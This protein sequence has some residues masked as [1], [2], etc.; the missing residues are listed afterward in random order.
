MENPLMSDGVLVRYLITLVDVMEREYSVAPAL[1]YSA[2]KLEPLPI[3]SAGDRVSVSYADKLWLAASQL[4][5]SELGLKLGAA[6]RYTSYASLGH[7]LMT[8]ETVGDAIRTAAENAHYVG[9]GHFEVS[10]TDNELVLTYRLGPEHPVCEQRAVASIVPYFTLSKTVAKSGAPTRVWLQIEEPSDVPQYKQFFGSTLSFGEPTSGV[11]WDKALLS[12]PMRDANPALHGLL[13]QHLKQELSQTNTILAQVGAV[14]D[15]VL[16]RPSPDSSLFNLEYCTG[17]LG[18]PRRSLQRA[19]TEEGTSY[20]AMLLSKR[21]ERACTLLR[22]E[23]D[24]VSDIAHELG[25]SEAAAFVRAFR[26][27]KKISPSKYRANCQITK[28]K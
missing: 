15:D 7:L 26:S 8:C 20:R 12:T 24:A 25:Y 5:D 21:M 6:I 14:I 27:V 10:E 22:E 16:S 2:A 13:L 1:L 23:K 3:G 28:A 9:A 11:A 17:V 4:A 19:L 18:I